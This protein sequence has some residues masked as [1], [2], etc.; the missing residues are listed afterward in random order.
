[1]RTTP[2]RPWKGATAEERRA[3]RRTRLLDAGLDVLG[4]VGWER[5]T[6][7][8]VC[9]EAGLTE[10]YFYESFNDREAL[11]LALFDAVRAESLAA[12]AEA[13]GATLERDLRTRARNAVAAGLAVLTDDPRKGRL[14][15]LES[16]R[17]PALQARRQDE[18]M[19]VAAWLEDVARESFEGEPMDPQ[20]TQANAIAI[21]AAESALATAYLDGTLDISRDRLVEHITEL[22][23]AVAR[24]TSRG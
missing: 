19:V 14:L 21:V 8:G 16:S 12:V 2:T 3:E 11:V 1:M 13:V 23:L 9:A 17:V 22:H 7:R 20:D 4:A 10:R 24:L 6:V 5:T 15:F 18:L